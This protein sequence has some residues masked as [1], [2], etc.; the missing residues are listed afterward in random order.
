MLDDLVGHRPHHQP[1]ET[2]LPAPATVLQ[3]DIVIITGGVSVGKYDLVEQVLKEL[4]ADFY[5]DGLKIR[6]G[7]PAVFGFCH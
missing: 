2:A 1:G 6:P 4:K 5:F 3:A 7:K